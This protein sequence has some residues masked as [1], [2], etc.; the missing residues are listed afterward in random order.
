MEQWH[1]YTLDLLNLPFNTAAESA[2][3]LQHSGDHDRLG[4]ASNELFVL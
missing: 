3:Y 2:L 1:Q 4:E